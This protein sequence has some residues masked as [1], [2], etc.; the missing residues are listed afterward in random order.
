MTK[1]DFL[2]KIPDI[3][4]HKNH[5][6]SELS[7][8]ADKVNQKGVCYLSKEKYSSC[9]SWGTTWQEVYN[10]LSQHLRSEGYMK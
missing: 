6:Y 8:T 3:I 1:S 5:G 2:S 10:N 4:E 7:I 9:G